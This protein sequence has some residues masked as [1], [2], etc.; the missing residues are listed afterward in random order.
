MYWRG[1]SPE[2]QHASQSRDKW[3]S[4]L[5]WMNGAGIML[6]PFAVQYDLLLAVGLVVEGGKM[7]EEIKSCVSEVARI[8]G[9]SGAPEAEMGGL[10]WNY[11]ASTDLDD[12][13]KIQA[14]ARV[15]DPD[16]LKK[17]VQDIHKIKNK[18][19]SN[20][21]D[22]ALVFKGYVDDYGR[23]IQYQV[24]WNQFE[25]L[26]RKLAGE[27]APK[28][29][30]KSEIPAGELY[31]EAEK[32]LGEG[33]DAEAIKLLQQ[34]VNAD[35]S[36]VEGWLLLGWLQ[37]ARGDAGQAIDSFSRWITRPDPP[38]EANIG[39]GFAFAMQGNQQGAQA[40][41]DIVNFES[42]GDPRPWTECG[43]RLTCLGMDKE[44][45]FCFEQ[46][47]ALDPRTRARW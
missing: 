47:R 11:L 13:K 41:F 2:M 45:R 22:A 17:F 6:S 32:K 25:S 27:P 8:L 3:K 37:L 9:L 29:A 39:L 44:A 35:P 18:L 16:G 10:F 28:E 1:N 14:V 19:E 24:T 5:A 26:Q 31:S 15:R 36:S 30:I 4:M 46:A 7:P 33:D 20:K 40:A 21:E 34:L 43:R 38:P 23:M 12:L 42:G